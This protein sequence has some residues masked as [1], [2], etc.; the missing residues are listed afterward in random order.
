MLSGCG[1]AAAVSGGAGRCGAH[2]GPR[3]AGAGGAGAEGAR[4]SLPLSPSLPV[5]PG[6]S[7]PPSVGAGGGAA[8]PPAAQ[9][10][11]A[12]AGKRGAELGGSRR[13]RPGEGAR[14]PFPAVSASLAP[15]SLGFLGVFCSISAT[16]ANFCGRA[17]A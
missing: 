8:L 10:R 4:S 11:A 5:P 15:S 14:F 13:P 17:A 1:G 2:L 16:G 7:L 3:P 6:P 12:P 9:P